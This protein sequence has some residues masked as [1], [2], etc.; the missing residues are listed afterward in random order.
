MA[1]TDR[2]TFDA[3][4]IGS[5]FGGAVAAQRLAECG[6][7][8]I[9]VLERGLP[10]PPGSF[11]RTPREMRD[12]V[13][14]P[15]SGNYGLIELLKFEHVTAVISA[16]LGG[17]SLVYANVM[18]RKPPET[19]AADESNGWRE[20][21]VSYDELE[22]GYEA[23]LA[24]LNP[25]E[26]PY[27][28]YAV[29]KTKAFRDAVREIGLEP[30]P[31]PI[32]VTFAQREG[33]PAEPGMPLLDDSGSVDSD[34][35]HHRPRRTCTLSGDCDFGCN[36]GAKNTLDFNFL[37]EFLR[38]PSGRKEI[39]TCCEAL[40]IAGPRPGGGYQVRYRQHAGARAQVR[41]RALA[42]NHETDLELLDQD[43]AELRTVRAKV[44]ILAGGTFGTTRLLL[45][46]RTV[47]PRLSAQLGCGFSAN[48]D[49]LKFARDC[50]E[51]GE[52]RN[53]APS[54][55]PV[56]TS[57]ARAEADG[58][59]TWLED[60]GYPRGIEMMW[61]VTE[62][63]GDLWN[64][65]DVG[66][67]SLRG[68]LLGNVGG[69]I[70]EALGNAHAST[71]MVALLAMGRDVPGGTM[72]LAGDA[73]TLDWDPDAESDNYF[74]FVERCTAALTAR[75]G[76]ELGDRGWRRRFMPGRGAC[77]HPLGGCRMGTSENEGVIDTHGEVFG[78][79]GLFVADGAAMPGPVGP[80]PSLTIGALSH[81][82]AGYAAERAGG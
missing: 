55:G 49:L 69:E 46:S 63:P 52:W 41:E 73:L 15:T 54:R 58:H 48:G 59:S 53:L 17:G 78:C 67:R 26:M 24:R 56:I 34:N 20:W 51:D 61:Q 39:R 44:V 32:A 79:E 2:D 12:N 25:T 47:L 5:G 76:G 57:Y 28:P 33:Q 21:P 16:G 64:M 37:S 42:E 36:E 31:A 11:A 19:F 70:M 29:P 6:V 38:H 3:I 72:D 22:E 23:V 62:M 80:N 65:R 8:D 7:N 82:I 75:L 1:D 30:E 27:G 43:M 4:V 45:S 35:L 81:R 13:W 77:A 10:Y 60:G 66:L 14:D 74:S 71:S 68:R 18:L 40:D 9:L 50:R